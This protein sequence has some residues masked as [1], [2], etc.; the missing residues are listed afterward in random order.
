MLCDDVNGFNDQ[1]KLQGHTNG[2]FTTIT[3]RME[4][5]RTGNG[6]A[7]RLSSLKEIMQNPTC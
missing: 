5:K 1:Y 4:R 3:R 2:V 6:R 7:G